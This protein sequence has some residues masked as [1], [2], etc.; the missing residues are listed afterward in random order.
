MNI[1]RQKGAAL[2]VTVIIVLVLSVIAVTATNT[3]Q[4]QQLLVRNNQQQM[5]VFNASHDELESQLEVFER[6]SQQGISSYVI[7]GLVAGGNGALVETKVF[8][9]SDEE[10]TLRLKN[11]D[12]DL[13]QSLRLTFRRLLGEYRIQ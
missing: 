11:H 13:N 9:T 2:L 6:L 3:N 7:E 5:L 10:F 8:G 12:A 1:E 4:M